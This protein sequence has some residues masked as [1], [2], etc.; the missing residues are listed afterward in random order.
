MITTRSKMTAND[1]FTHEMQRVAEHCQIFMID[2]YG[3]VMSHLPIHDPVLLHAEVLQ[4]NHHSLA[5][6]ESLVYFIQKFPKLKTKLEGSM[7]KLYDQFTD[8]QGLQDSLV[9]DYDRIDHLWHYLANLKGCEGYRFNLLF[10]VVKC[11]LLLPHS[12]AAEERVFQ[13]YQRTIRA[14]LSN[15]TSLPSILTCKT[16]CFNHI[17]CYQFQH[18]KLL[19]EKA[20]KA[21]TNY[22]TDQKK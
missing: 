3:Y 20:K 4:F 9:D 11:I 13:R 8:Y 18:S 10:D 19:L 6:F 15:K 21:A 16:Y 1:F 17:N 14:S 22:D 2:A 7:D 5:N 12:N